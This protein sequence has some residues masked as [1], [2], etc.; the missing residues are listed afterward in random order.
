MSVIDD[1]SVMINLLEVEL[2]YEVM[3]AE[4]FDAE[5]VSW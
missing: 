3:I 4:G 5:F 1:V 2:G